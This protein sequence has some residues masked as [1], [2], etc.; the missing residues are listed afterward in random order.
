[1][2]DAATLRTIIAAS[3]LH[4]VAT[5]VDDTVCFLWNAL[6]SDPCV[7]ISPDSV[8]TVGLLGAVSSESPCHPDAVAVLD[9]DRLLDGAD[10]DAAFGLVDAIEIALQS[11]GY[12]FGASH[13]GLIEIL[14]HFA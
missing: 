9:V 3:Y 6:S 14:R 7:V 8:R 5:I 2:N 11:E 4:D 13:D 1:M 12:T 10:E